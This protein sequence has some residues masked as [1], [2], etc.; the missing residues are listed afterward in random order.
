MA[1]F[2]RQSVLRIVVVHWLSAALYT[3]PLSAQD[4]TAPAGETGAEAIAAG[5]LVH[6]R[7]LAMFRLGDAQS[8]V[9]LLERS[10]LNFG[11]SA[12]ANQN[13]SLWAYG[14]EGRPLAIVEL[15]RGTNP[16][17]AWVHAITLTGDE[18]VIVKTPAGTDWRP[19]RLQIEPA[20]IPGA[21]PPEATEA[22]RL[23]Q[24]KDLSR[25]FTAHEFWDPDNSRFELRLLVQPVHRYRD[26]RRG[27]HDG[28]VFVLAHGTNPEV[29][30]LIEALGT[31]LSAARWHFSLARLGSAELHVALDGKEVWRRDRAPGITG[32]PS[33]PYWLFVA[34]ADE[35]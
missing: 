25:R 32:Q 34:P 17:D 33:D 35:R 22:R 30:L 18:R 23:R 12:R 13:G 11:D 16:G 4:A 7:Q 1:M 24:M 9:P 14:R 26:P 6:M 28:A 29:L 3:A 2:F 19:A 5:S 10:L 8:E 15:F 20:A 31:E 27:I 21:P